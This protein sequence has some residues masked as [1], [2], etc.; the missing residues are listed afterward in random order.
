MAW[1]SSD[2]ID[3]DPEVS[4]QMTL[5]IEEFREMAAPKTMHA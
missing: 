2:K 5:A 3:S 4:P 1:F